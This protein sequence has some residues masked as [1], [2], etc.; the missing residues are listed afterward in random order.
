MLV[1]RRAALLGQTKAGLERQHGISVSIV[2][3]DLTEPDQ[4]AAMYAH[5]QAQGL[6]LDYLVNNAGYGVT[7]ET[8]IT[9]A[10]MLT[11]DV[12]GR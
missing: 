12:L 9:C 11:L 5:C 3:A 8:V 2:V 1:V 6:Q 4:A 7:R 10:N